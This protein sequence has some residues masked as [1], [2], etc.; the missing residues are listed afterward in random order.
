M[1]FLTT[2]LAWLKGAGEWLKTLLPAFLG[3][4]LGR[5]QVQAADAEVELKTE[6]AKNAVLEKQ[7]DVPAVGSWDEFD[8]VVQPDDKRK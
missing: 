6:K 7:R 2:A 8:R 1:A 5:K 3:L 4:L